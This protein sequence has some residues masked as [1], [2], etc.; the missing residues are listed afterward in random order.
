MRDSNKRLVNICL[1]EEDRSAIV[2]W[3]LVLLLKLSAQY[4]NA[5]VH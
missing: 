3:S 2:K 5:L 4:L 1:W